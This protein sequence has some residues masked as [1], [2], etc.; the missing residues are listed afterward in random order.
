[1]RSRRAVTHIGARKENEKTTDYE[2]ARASKDIDIIIGG[3]SHTL[4]KPDNATEGY[5]S[6]VENADGRPVLV[7]QTGRYGKYLGY[8]KI[9]LDDLKTETPADFDYR[10]IPVTDRFPSEALDRKMNDFITPYRDRLKA[11]DANVIGYCT[12]DMDANARTGRY[13]NWSGDFAKWFGSLKA[14]SLRAAGVDFPEVD[15]GMMNVGG[16][17]HHAKKGDVTEGQMLATF[18]FSNHMVIVEIS[19]RDFIEAMKVAAEK[20]GEAVSDE[21]RVVGDGKNAPVR[22]IINDREMDPDAKYVFSTIDYLANGN[23]DFVTLANGR[24]LWRDDVEMCAPMIR[25]V[26]ML[27]SLGLP[28]DG[29]PR[30]RFMAPVDIQSG[31]PDSNTK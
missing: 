5:P 24:V 17:R 14:D 4:I 25:Y 3:H 26:K 13:V 23:D 27:T 22:V 19:G 7:A 12:A 9:D 18:P 8:I 28:V 31:G 15:F 20:G 10:L 29:D 2:L 16:I 21:I 6:V 1:M 11:V 30:P